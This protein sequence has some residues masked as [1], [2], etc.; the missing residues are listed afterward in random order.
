MRIINWCARWCAEH[1]LG[2]AVLFAAVITVPTAWNLEHRTDTNAGRIEEVQE[3]VDDEVPGVEP[4][5]PIDDES[6]SSTEP[7]APPTTTGPLS[8]SDEQI[9]QIIQEFCRQ[10]DCRPIFADEREIQEAEVQDGEVQDGEVQDAEIQ[11]GEAQEREIQEAEI[12]E[13]PIPGPPGPA[14]SPG[15][16]CPADY[17]LREVR[18]PSVSNQMIFLVCSRG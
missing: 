9:I 4:T 5:T 15:Q 14:G 18:I 11:D 1:V 2:A 6:P 3:E 13:A 16:T 7:G 17:T 12:Q 8:I 10:N